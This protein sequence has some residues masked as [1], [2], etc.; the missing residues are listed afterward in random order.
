MPLGQL[1]LLHDGARQALQG[2]AQPLVFIP[3]LLPDRL[4]IVESAC[5]NPLQYFH[6]PPFQ[7]SRFLFLGV[8]DDKGDISIGHHRIGI[9]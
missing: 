9:F 1:D 4:H 5:S 2:M 7:Y 6:Q 8:I 3:P